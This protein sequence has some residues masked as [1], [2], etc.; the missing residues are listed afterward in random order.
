MGA[1]SAAVAS[2]SSLHLDLPPGSLGSAIATL[3]DETGASILT[4]DAALLGIG[5][6]AIHLEGSPEVILA[7]LAQ[8]AGL[9]LV[10]SGPRSWRISRAVPPQPPKRVE[11]PRTTVS[12]I[13]VQAT[14]RPELLSDYPA[15][16]VRVAGAELNRYGAAP[17]TGGLSAL[18]PILTSTDWG[19]GQEKLFLRGIADSSF[20]GTSPTLVGEYLGDQPLTYDAPD[21][22]LRLYDVSS[23]EV[24]A[25]PQGTLYGAG[26]LAGI[27]RIEPNAPV[28]DRT[29]GSV[30]AGGT[31]TAHGADG[32]DLG[33]VLNLPLIEGRLALR[34]VGYAENDGGYIDDLE[35]GLKDVNEAQVRGGRATLRWAP[36]GGWTV[37]FGGVVQRIANR[38]ASYVNTADPAWTRASALSQ[39]STD[40]FVSGDVT[41]SGR[42]G[43]VDVRSTTGFVDQSQH[44]RF[45]VLRDGLTPGRFDEAER[46]QQVSQELR[47]SGGSTRTSW[48]MGLSYL[49]QW[50]S[51]A[52]DYGSLYEPTPLASVHERTDELT[53]YGE[54]T[55]KFG[56]RVSL[57][58]GLRYATEH[59]AGDLV[60]RQSPLLEAFAIKTS[61]KGSEHHLLPSAALSYELA[62]ATTLFVRE[63]SGVRLGGLSPAGAERYASDHIAT[64]ETGLRRGVPG[65]DRVALSATG[66]Y[67]QW[68]NIQADVL[69]GIG[70]PQIANIGDGRIYSLDASAAVR[71]AEGLSL[72]A[73][74]FLAS[75][76]LDPTPALSGE[77]AGSVLPDVARNG[78]TVAL[79][80][81]GR[82]FDGPVFE[83]GV[84]ARHIGPS[85]LGLGPFLARPQGDYTAVALGGGL[86]F[87]PTSVQLNISNLMD[88]RGP[89]FGIGTPFV[90][91]SENDVT[92]L[93]PRTIRLG[94]RH[95]F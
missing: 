84:Q 82:L 70:F 79:D 32:G 42:V 66:A 51:M 92:P 10:R 62:G 74:G 37:D 21:P 11:S 26:A 39:P 60:D 63:G 16:I 50:E 23:V 14:K 12:Q 20:T 28:L 49:T 88:S 45:E 73:S 69:Q 85:L 9:A 40:T 6:P 57:T 48:V 87:G 72:D 53:G 54:A 3:S 80:Y 71:I 13:V 93:R 36:A 59:Q 31:N 27:I 61:L 55:R 15:E 22:D 65:R 77:G 47:L 1:G 17:D 25:G 52:R 90:T 19:A 29:S 4:S 75:S 35:R 76:R 7:R 81:Q 43:G 58:L 8:D 67:S 5:L 30:W 78:G 64:V 33:G 18:A 86:R 24:L 2:A 95:D 94:L 68:N 44:E 41:V 91:L 38:D 83:G 89:V 56:P 46:P 34:A